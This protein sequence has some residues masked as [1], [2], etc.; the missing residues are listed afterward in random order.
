[1]KLYIIIIALLI[2]ITSCEKILVEKNGGTDNLAIFDEYAKIVQ[3]K[4]AMLE[5]KKVDII[6]LRDSIKQTIGDESQGELFEKLAFI[7]RKLHDGHSG[8]DSPDSSAGFD[9]EAGYAP[10]FHAGILLENYIGRD[11]NPNLK[12]IFTENETSARAVY[13]F[14][15]QNDNIA[16]IWIPSWDVEILDDEIESI[17]LHIKDAKAL[18][19]DMR[20]NTGGDP[21]LATKFAAYFTGKPVYTGFERFKIGPLGDDF[22][23]SPVTL[24]PAKSDNKFLKPVAVLTDRLCYSA[25]TT[26]AYSVNPI[27]NITFIGQRTGG[28]SGSVADG[29]LAN[30]WKWSLSTSE[31]IDHLDNH[32]DDGF[33]PDIAV[34]LDTLDKSQ[35]EVIERAILEL[36]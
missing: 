14:L 9:I 3:E 25:S 32:L 10:G 5:F 7:T 2:S 12:A 24:Q 4:Y 17:F 13:G 35:D 27:E 15:P 30:G 33:N 36:Q 26:F 29:Y 19:F 8:L 16:Y 20:Q 6:S 23:D 18:I 28:G 22:S 1:M 31:F 21:S 11:I 34:A